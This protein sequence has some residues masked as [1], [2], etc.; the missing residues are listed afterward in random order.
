M[1]GTEG[2]AEPPRRVA[3]RPAAGWLGRGSPF[4]KVRRAVAARTT[5]VRHSKSVALRCFVL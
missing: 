2:R 5:S 4:Q 1:N 3:M